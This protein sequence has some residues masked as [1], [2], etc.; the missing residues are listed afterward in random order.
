MPWRESLSQQHAERKNQKLWRE[1]KQ[2]SSAQSIEVI[3][4][5]E[6]YLNFC[7]ND[8]LGLANHPK[9]IDAAIQAAQ[10]SGVGSGASHLVCGHHNSH[11]KLEQELSGFV[12]AESA[13]LFST[14]YMANL[15]VAQCFLGKSDLLLQDKLNHASLL[16]AAKHS[17][18]DFKRYAHSNIEHAGKLLQQHRLENPAKRCLITTDSIF[19]MDGDLAPINELDRLAREQEAVLLID[20][21]HGFGVL[22][23]KGQGSYAELALKPNQH[24]LMLGTLG[25]AAGSFGA[26]IAGDRIYIDQLRQFARTYIYTTALPMLIAET[27]RAALRIMQKEPQ[28]QE[29]LR[30]SIQYLRKGI[31][32]LGLDLM[33]SSSPIQPILI[34]SA[35]SA[36]TASEILKQDHIWVTAIR[37]PTVPKGSSRL[38]ITLCSEHRFEHIDRLL[39]SLSKIIKESC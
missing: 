8:Y 29:R 33:E 32:A 11:E 2:L 31:T 24:R 13:I 1:P 28:R 25:K 22:G 19:S 3:R 10:S 17:Q 27:T 15:A 20:D 30:Q 6:T 26:F 39:H 14:G 35:A 7:S 12:E 21:A 4:D 38:R 9:L 16:D 18:C 34:G 37:P 36:L 23:D 5:G